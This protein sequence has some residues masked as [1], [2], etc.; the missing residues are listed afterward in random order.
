[1]GDRPAGYSIEM[2]VVVEGQNEV[3]PIDCAAQL[4]DATCQVVTCA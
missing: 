4:T 3:H 2:P 1:M